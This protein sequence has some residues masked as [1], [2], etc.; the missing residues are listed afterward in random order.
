MKKDAEE[1]AEE[2]KKKREMIDIKNTADTMIYTTEKMMKDV[3]EK[4]IA[5]T[6][7][8]KKAVEDALAKMKEVKDGDDAE[9]IKTASEALS[10]AGQAVGMKMY[11]QEQSK[12]TESAQGGSANGGEDGAV[13]GEVVDE[14]TEEEPKA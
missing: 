12:T 11:Q 7:E 4:K 3:E 1:H 10:K 6:D 5:I 2:D 14:S 13:E 9:A 8:E